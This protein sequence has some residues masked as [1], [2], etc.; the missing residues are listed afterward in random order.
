MTRRS[1]SKRGTAAPHFI[2]DRRVKSGDDG[3]WLRFFRACLSAKGG[4]FSDKF[5]LQ[6]KLRT[7][8]RF[9]D[10]RSRGLRTEYRHAA[11]AWLHDR[12]RHRRLWLI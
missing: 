11:P 5:M 7:V 4:D 12:D 1:R 3:N 8:S 2:G 10:E 6:I 9:G